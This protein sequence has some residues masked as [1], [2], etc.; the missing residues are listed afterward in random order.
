MPDSDAGEKSPEF[1]YAVRRSTRARRVSLRYTALEGLVVIVPEAFDISR[2]P[3]IVHRKKDWIARVAGQFRNRMEHYAGEPDLPE[4]VLLRAAGRTVSIKYAPSSR[5]FAVRD[6]GDTLLVSGRYDAA[7]VRKFLREWLKRQASAYLVPLMH[8]LAAEQGVR[9]SA[10]R[11]RLQR[12]RWGSCS[13]GN[14]INLN[15][16]LMLLPEP[17][18]RYVCLHELAHCKHHNHSKEFWQHLASLMPD[19]RRIDAA[20]AGAWQFVPR[21]SYA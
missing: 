5:P 4:T 7:R 13:I 9:L 10:V 3:E 6:T 17:M 19:A 8:G 2:V 1:V 11:V 21:W 18:A 20:L 14:A 16:R 12:S 15:A